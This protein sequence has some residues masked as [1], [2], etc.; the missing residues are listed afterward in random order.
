MGTNTASLQK[1]MLTP[2]G[3]AV[4]AALATLILAGCATTPSAPPSARAVGVAARQGNPVA[5]FDW[6]IQRL[7]RAHGP[8]QHAA[9]V[10]W[11]GRAARANLAVAQV[12][13]AARRT[14][15]PR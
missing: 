8:G 2:S 5:Q 6:G 14:G 4:A 7:S 3:Q 10:E 15:G 13:L 12:R 9:G 1:R 11:I